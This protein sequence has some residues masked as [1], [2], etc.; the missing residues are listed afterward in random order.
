MTPKSVGICVMGLGE[1]GSIHARNLARV[2]G[3]VVSLASRRKDALHALGTELHVPPERWFASYEAAL[4]SPQIDAVVIA[5]RPTEHPTHIEAVAAAGKHVFC[6]KPLGVAVRDIEQ[7]LAAVSDARRRQHPRPLLFMTGFHRRYDPTYH[8][9]KQL[10]EA[11]RIGQPTV[12]KGTSGDPDYPVKY[13]RDIGYPSLLLDLA[14]HDIDLARWLLRSEVRQVHTVCA[15]LVY[16]HLLGLGD[17]DTGVVV[18][19]MENGTL[20]SLHLSRAFQYGYNVTSEVVG[21]RGSLQLGELKGAGEAVRVLGADGQSAERIVW[22]FGERF[23][24]AFAREMQVFAEAVRSGRLLP[25]APT[26]VDGLEATRVAE[27]MVRSWRTG[28]P[29]RVER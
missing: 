22:D 15:A 23:A 28:R 20:A 9:G 5:T 4:A 13:Q 27:A 8:R 2:P 7:A 18:L 29:Q 16:P 25:D 12:F 11:D 10:L 24:Q 26:E 1:M 3:V 17:A 6:E 21:T 19:E 14:V